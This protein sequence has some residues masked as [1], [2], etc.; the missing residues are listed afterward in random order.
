MTREELLDRICVMLGGRVAEELAL[1]DISTGAQNDLERASETARQMV[2]RFGMSTALGPLTY[3]SP[4]GP[5]YLEG[6]ASFVDR[7]FSE[8]TGQQ[9]DAE[10]RQIVDQ[11]H[12]RATRIVGDQRALLDALVTRLLVEET[13]DQ[14]ALEE[15]V[16]AHTKKAAE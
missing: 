11:Q 4:S 10:V 13:L 12:E 5:S 3:G 2:C 6:P 7:N 1:T 14:A 9:I 8:K 15:L 16:T